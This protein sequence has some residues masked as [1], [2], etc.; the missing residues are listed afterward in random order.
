MWSSASRVRAPSSD[1]TQ[2]EGTTTRALLHAEHRAPGRARRA[3]EPRAL[4]GRPGPAARARTP[5]GLGRLPAARAPGRA[6]L[7]RV[8]ALGARGGLDVARAGER[9]RGGAEA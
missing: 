5:A 9:A 8:R 1:A 4:A 2:S 6:P 7:G 3:R